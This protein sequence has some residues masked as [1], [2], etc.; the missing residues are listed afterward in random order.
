MKVLVVDDVAEN[1]FLLGRL[2]SA[3][4]HEVELASDGEDAIA[5]E[6]AASYDIVLLDL[7]MP[8]IDG[9]EVARTIRKREVD[10]GTRRKPI[11]AISAFDVRDLGDQLKACGIDAFMAKPLRVGPLLAL[12]E[13]EAKSAGRRSIAPNP[14]D[15]VVEVDEELLDIVPLFLES[16]RKDALRLGALLADANFEEVARVGHTVRGSAATFGF[17]ALKELGSRLQRAAEGKEAGEVARVSTELTRYLEA[18]R[19]IPAS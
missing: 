10:Q 12:C 7:G 13:A 4:G 9:F 15:S 1:R 2:L 14:D 8:N 17:E 5:K 18:V 19:F 6:A 3:R 11:V 16:R